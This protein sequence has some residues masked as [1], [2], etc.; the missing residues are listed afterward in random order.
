MKYKI[1]WCKVNKYYLNKRLNYFSS[2]QKIKN[3]KNNDFIIATC[4][5]TDKAK[6][7]FIKETKQQVKN[8][9]HIYLTGCAVFDKWQKMEE[10]KFYNI[11]PEL[12]EFK[13]HITLLWEEPNR[14]DTRETKTHIFKDT[15]NIYTKKFIVIQN[16][17]DSHCSF[18]LTI[19][20][21]WQSQNISATEIIQEINDFVEIWWKEIVLTG[22]NLA[23]RWASDTKKPQEN[24]FAKL[25]QQILD[26]TKI[27]RIRISSLWPEFL[28]EDFFEVIKNTRFLPHFHISIQSFSDKILKY[29][30]RNYNSKLLDNIITRL[31]NLD[32]PDKSQISIWADIIVWFPWET[33]QDFQQTLDWI[34]KHNI[35][36][37]HAF[38]FSSHEHGES[39]PAHNF[40]DQI[41]TQIKKQRATQIKKIW[42]KIRQNFIKNNNWIT[43]QVLIEEQ[44][45]W[46]RK[47]RT[48]NYIQVELSWEYTKWEIIKTIL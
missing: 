40:A 48:G 28:N 17:C 35:N 2:K 21:R 12:S 36:K 37:L 4:V 16:G 10:D 19:Q 42:D 15:A 46:K 22:I 6:S 41:S 14:L 8:D 25:L 7:K 38:P 30:N 39:I 32:R 45:N 34:T 9:K 27:E 29:M 11:Y 31:K 47:W 23:A 3:K 33:E 26:Q 18:C 20:K 43:H 13:N 24:K 44:K 5:V 1:F